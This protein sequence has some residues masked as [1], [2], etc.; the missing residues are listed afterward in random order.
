MLRGDPILLEDEALTTKWVV[1]GGGAVPAGGEV[2]VDGIG[3][4]AYARASLLCQPVPTIMP[5]SLIPSEP[6]A[7]AKFH[8][9]PAGKRSASR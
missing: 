5:L 4:I 2:E 7:L 6:D 8:P 9:E 1:V 3:T